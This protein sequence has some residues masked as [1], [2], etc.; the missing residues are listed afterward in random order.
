MVDVLRTFIATPKQREAAITAASSVP[1]GDG[2]FLSQDENGNCVSSG[3]VSEALVEALSG[4]C[5][6][7]E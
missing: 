5:T 6:I 2:M 7:S 3:Y 1:G 4:L